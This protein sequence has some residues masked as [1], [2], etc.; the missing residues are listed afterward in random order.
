MAE[1]GEILSLL[2]AAKLP[3][4]V[5]DAFVAEGYDTKDDFQNCFRSE[6]ALEK[7]LARWLP[8]KADGV[9]AENWETHPVAGK[10][11]KALLPL[12]VKEQAAVAPRAGGKSTMPEDPA[13]GLLAKR[14]LLPEKRKELVKTFLTAFPQEV[15]GDEQMPSDCLMELVWRMKHD[16]DTRWLPWKHVVS[17]KQERDKTMGCAPGADPQGDFQGYLKFLKLRDGFQDGI[18]VEVNGSFDRVANLL[19]CRAY[20]LAMQGL[21]SLGVLRQYNIKFMGLYK[22]VPE[23]SDRRRANVQEAEA[24][25]RAAW[26]AIE[27]LVG[28]AVALDDSILEITHARS[29]LQNGLASRAKP[30][31]AL[32]KAPGAPRGGGPAVTSQKRSPPWHDGQDAGAG[33][34]YQKG[35]CWTKQRTGKCTRADCPFNH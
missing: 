33:K 31:Q 16:Q 9:T 35:M 15:L 11:R 28:S 32:P 14:R 6:A 25:D 26:E 8:Q 17:K 5:S 29:I 2:V 27:L 4:S 20:A 22:L 12:L 13:D 24:A 18:E 21:A 3:T 1:A 19:A 30:A 7:F 34:K 23:S 10:L